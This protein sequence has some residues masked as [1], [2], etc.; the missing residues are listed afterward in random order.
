V[1]VAK[2]RAAWAPGTHGYD[3][4]DAYAT[5][6]LSL[7]P[8]ERV[9]DK[10]ALNA[11]AFFQTF[12]AKDTLL[13]YRPVYCDMMRRVLTEFAVRDGVARVEL[14]TGIPGLYELNGS[15]S[16]ANGTVGV[17]RAIAQSVKDDT[18]GAFRG[19]AIIA[20]GF[21]EISL[22][23]MRAYMQEALALR[24]ANP[25]MV[26]GFDIAGEEDLGFPLL[27]YAALF[28]ELADNATAAGTDMP[29]TLHVGET[30]WGSNAGVAPPLNLSATNLF[31]AYLLGAVRLG[32][33]L[34][35]AK[36]PLLQQR[37]LAAGAA[38]ETCPIS[39]QELQYIDDLRDH[40]ATTLLAAGLPITISPD[41]PGPLGYGSVAFDW[42]QAYVA[43]D[44][45]LASLKRMARNSI[46]HSLAG[47][48]ERALLMQ[49]WEASWA[50]WIA[51]FSQ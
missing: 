4:F 39:N 25:D 29:L 30:D 13:F 33:A 20:T 17:L 1:S 19:L 11:W 26:V 38:I 28:L 50:A 6:L 51:G 10:A 7:G 49:A 36:F 8:R 9:F 42:W 2:L 3:S 46:A 47:D 15:V 34:A 22:P 27:H 41:D 32:H 37:F 24:L 40:P 16:D 5:A 12:F 14:R 44:V 35:L 43:W 31:D 23:A 21:R 18:G 45:D 48:S